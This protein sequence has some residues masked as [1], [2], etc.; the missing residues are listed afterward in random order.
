MK[1]VLENPGT[2]FERVIK[3]AV[4]PVLVLFYA[5]WCGQCQILAPLLARLARE[6]EGAVRIAQINLDD[7]PELAGRY[8][9]FTVPTLMLFHGG[10]PIDRL[11]QM[12]SFLELEA[13]LRGVLADYATERTA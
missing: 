1:T 3:S 4:E 5:S 2:G 10:V 6:L 9:I 11:E 12:P 13:R 8:S 7:R